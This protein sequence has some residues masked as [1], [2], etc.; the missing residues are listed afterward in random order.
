MRRAGVQAFLFT[1]LILCTQLSVQGAGDEEAFSYQ[2]AETWSSKETRYQSLAWPDGS[3]AGGIDRDVTSSRTYVTDVTEHTVRVYDAAGVEEAVLGGEGN[4]AGRFVEPR[5]IDVAADGTLVVSDAGNNR[6]QLLDP[7][8]E[9]IG[10]WPVANPRGL[11]VVRDWI[12]VVSSGDNAI[13]AYDFNGT[14]RR[15]TDLSPVS[16]APE[17]LAYIDDWSSQADPPYARFLVADAAGNR[18]LEVQEG[19]PEPVVR[20]DFDGVRAIAYWNNAVV[21]GADALGVAV[22]D[23]AGQVEGNLPFARVNDIEL[24]QDGTGSLLAAA[25]R[26]GPILIPDPMLII[27]GAQLGQLVQPRSIAVGNEV[28]VGDTVPNLHVWSRQGQPLREQVLGRLSLGDVAAAGSRGYAFFRNVGVVRVEQGGLSN[29]LYSVSKRSGQWPVALDAFLETAAVLDIAQQAVHFL[30]SDLTN[31][32]GW[33]TEHLGSLGGI[34]V[35][36][37]DTSVFVANQ[38]TSS[39]EVWS[40]SGVLVQ[41]VVV[42]AGPR[43]VAAG[44]DGNAYVLTDA[45]WV[46][47]YSPEGDVVGS[48]PVGLAGD[49]PAD[50]ALDHEG[51]LYVADSTGAVRVYERTEGEPSSPGERVSI[52]DCVAL[53]NKTASPT[54]LQL[55]ES[56]GVQLSFA[57]RCPAR[58]RPVDIVLVVDQSGSMDDQIDAAIDAA[59]RLLSR[60]GLSQTRA[61]VVAFDSAAYEIQP[62]SADLTET[63]RHLLS[64]PVDSD[65]GGTN[66]VAGLE[67]ALETLMAT[68]D[69]NHERA[70]V[71]LTDGGH[72]DPSVPESELEPVVQSIREEGLT[73][74]TIGLGPSADVQTL[75]RIATDGSHYYYAPGATDLAEI[76]DRIS[77]RLLSVILLERAVTI[78]VLPSNMSYLPGSGTP[79]EPAYDPVARTLRWDYRDLDETGFQ[80]GYRIRPLETGSWPTNLEAAVSYED[81]AGHGG[82]IVFPVPRVRVLAATPTATVIPSSTASPTPTTSTATPS[83]TPEY[84]VSVTPTPSPA[85]SRSPSVSPTMTLVSTPT[86]TRAHPSPTTTPALK[87]SRV[88]LPITLVEYCPPRGLFTDVSIVVDAST[89]MH[90]PTGDRSRKIDVAIES[91]GAFLDGLRLQTGKDRAAIIA[92]NER[93]RTLQHLTSNREDLKAALSRIRIAEFSRVDLGVERAMVEL[94]ARGRPGHVQAMVVLSDGMVNPVSGDEAVAAARRAQMEDITVYVVGVGPSMD[95]RVLRQMA[96]GSE[97][98]HP[99]PDP[100]LIRAIYQD[101]TKRVPCPPE[102]YWGHR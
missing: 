53:V 91:I 60:A 19:G 1:A 51:R 72:N 6:I 66:L 24:A 49:A 11:E 98:Y 23:D 21:S 18:V 48:W 37:T 89:S 80:V 42:I 70:I 78:D 52:G 74:Y 3:D 94:I 8:G 16:E 61:A 25:G 33:S 92:F 28:L 73:L 82:R 90:G 95:E 44:P 14:L 40:L 59:I 17:M 93:A 87:P 76:Y 58:D 35:A 77:Q 102:A 96:S 10:G 15:T 34:D 101:L 68:G 71:L 43:R 67:R 75:E 29:D 54:V 13:H 32:S 26:D 31:P 57:A 99:A 63:V 41:E 22:V 4:E 83:P 46:A 84:R 27:L 79:V 30:N 5:D 65:A 56:V 62:L 86:H 64:I 88:Y 45:G 85:A 38:A 39:L 50:L 7:N 12:Y 100:L 81:E 69:P 55:G 9:P 97:R 36:L 47:A 2:L 20:F